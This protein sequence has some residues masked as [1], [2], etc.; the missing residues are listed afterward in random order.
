MC[1]TPVGNNELLQLH[2]DHVLIS[3]TVPAGAASAGTFDMYID[4]EGKYTK[5]SDLKDPACKCAATTWGQ[6][7]SEVVVLQVRSICTVRDQNC[8]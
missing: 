1:D 4:F 6:N 3:F 7:S 8:T 2:K 5:L